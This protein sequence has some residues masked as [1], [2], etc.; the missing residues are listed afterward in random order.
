MQTTIEDGEELGCDLLLAAH[1]AGKIDDVVLDRL[2][3]S[4]LYGCAIADAQELG[5]LTDDVRGHERREEV[6]VLLAKVFEG[7]E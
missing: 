4:T 3:E 1:D 7:V 2:V 6:T 5:T